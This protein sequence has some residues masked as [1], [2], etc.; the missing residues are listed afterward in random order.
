M[1]VSLLEKDDMGESILSV[2]QECGRI[3]DKLTEVRTYT[4]VRYASDVVLLI[5]AVATALLL[6]TAA[7]TA[8]PGGGKSAG[9]R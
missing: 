3:K 5:R 4:S 1:R 7:S 2:A 8:A 9:R 6:R